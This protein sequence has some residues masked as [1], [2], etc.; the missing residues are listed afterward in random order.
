MQTIPVIASPLYTVMNRSVKSA[1]KIRAMENRHVLQCSAIA[2]VSLCLLIT[3]FWSQDGTQLLEVSSLRQKSQHQLPRISC[4]QRCFYSHNKDVRTP[5]F[6][7]SMWIHRWMCRSRGP[8]LTDFH[9][10]HR[11]RVVW[12]T[13]VEFPKARLSEHRHWTRPPPFYFFDHSEVLIVVKHKKEM[14][15]LVS[16]CKLCPP[17]QLRK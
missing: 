1:L 15:G 7:L 5:K 13:R 3:Q 2:P 8:Y 17:L 10:L 4:S 16:L 11:S 9:I 14:H 6:S 12:F